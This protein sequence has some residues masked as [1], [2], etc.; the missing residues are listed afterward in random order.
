MQRV[1]VGCRMFGSRNSPPVKPDLGKS[2]SFMAGISSDKT[3]KAARGSEEGTDNS[4]LFLLILS[5]LQSSFCTASSVPLIGRFFLCISV[6]HFSSLNLSPSLH[7]RRLEETRFSSLAISELVI[8][9]DWQLGA[10]LACSM[11]LPLVAASF[12]F[13]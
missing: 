9:C 3:W 2:S 12:S 8:S 11:M 4:V 7:S 6:F 13:T 5:S 10:T 1:V